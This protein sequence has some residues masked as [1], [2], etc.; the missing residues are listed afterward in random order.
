MFF[1]ELL[2]AIT[3]EFRRRRLPFAIGGG[4]AVGLRGVARLTDDIDLVV[5]GDRDEE[6]IDALASLG[7]R[8]LQRYPGF[9]NHARGEGD[10]ERVDLLFV[11]DETRDEIFRRASEVTTE[12]GRFPVLHP[13]HLVAMKLFAVK[14]NPGRTLQDLQDVADLL[15]RGTVDKQT[16]LVYL[17]RYGLRERA[18]LL[19]IE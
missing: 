3:A 10:E 19:G 9:S 7:F 4:I 6:A 2:T 13:D 16:V 5:D 14:Q 11:R 1:S 15:G 8:T 18:Q 17:T 12:Y